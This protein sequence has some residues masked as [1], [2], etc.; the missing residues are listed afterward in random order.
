MAEL[1]ERRHAM[2][3]QARRDGRTLSEAEQADWATIDA[4]HERIG[5]MPSP[6]AF[7]PDSPRQEGHQPDA[8]AARFLTSDG[9]TVYALRPNE[10]IA[11]LP[12]AEGRVTQPLSLGKA[13]VGLVSGRWDG[14]RAERLAMAEGGNSVGGYLV[15]EAMMTGVIDL[16][17][18]QSAVIRAGAITLPWPSASD[19]LVMARVASAPTFQVVAENT[20]IPESDVT[21]DQ[22]RFSA[23]K[24][25]GLVTMS[26]ELAEDAPNAAALVETTLAK[27]LAAE[28][29]RQALLGVGNTEMNGLL[30]WPGVA[31]TESV[32][33]VEWLDIHNAAVLV[34]TRNYE[35]GGYIT[36]PTIA[37]DLDIIQ[38][39]TAGTW[40]GAPPSLQGVRRFESTN[41]PDADIFMGD[42]SQF[43]YA[44]RTD[45]RVELTTTGGDK[46]FEKHQVKIKITWRGDVNALNRNAFQV[47]TG[48]TT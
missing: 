13:L 8:P 16:A 41:C 40:L 34:R 47:L 11:D 46:T 48:V 23:K 1:D 24:I 35:P 38:A 2:L 17:R 15:P 32:G 14:A 37:G 30:N 5:N 28:L 20:E 3:S 6:L 29:D 10:Q 45:A 26:R 21:F 18:A 9:K 12:R 19:E 44:I 36:S 31:T 33:A 27:A 42:W 25:A 22:V 4:E 39:D 43:V 7:R